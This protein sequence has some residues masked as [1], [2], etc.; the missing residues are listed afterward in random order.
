MK[1]ALPY[2]LAIA[3]LL[4]AGS[5][6]AQ[7]LVS[8]TPRDTLT[9]PEASFRL[10]AFGLFPQYDVEIADVRYTMADIGGA[11]D[12]VSGAVARPLAPA[13]TA[14]PRLAY[15][16]GTT[17][18][19]F[20]VPS[21]ASESAFE[22]T[23]LLATQGYLTVGPDYLGMGEDEGFHPYVHAR[24]EA[25][26]GIRMLQAL[27]TD[28]TYAAAANEQLFLTGYSQGG[29]ASMAMH[30]L[31]VEE[32]SGEFDVT[33]AA[34][35]SGPYSISTVMKDTVILRD[36]AFTSPAFLPYT[37]LGYMTAYPELERG[38]D[39][40]FRAPYVALVERFRDE[41]EAGTYPL[42]ELNEDLLRTYAEVEGDSAFFPGRYLDIDFFQ[43]LRKDVDD[44]FNV[45]LRENDVF[46]FENPDPTELLY[47]RGDDQVTYLNATVAL[48]S[49]LARGATATTARNLGD[50]RDH[51]RCALPA[52]ANAARFFAT[53]Q[54]VTSATEI[55]GAGAWTYAQ[56]EGGLRVYL[57]A[58][59]GARYR[60][61]LVDA[62]GRVAAEVAHYTSGDFVA[63]AGLPAGLAV[64]RIT[65]DRGRAA[66]RKLILR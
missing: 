24:T 31:I 25:L 36:S 9:S 5:A 35:L 20:D 6:R 53:F 22:P 11:I 63:T 4:S 18:T 38:L 17:A 29:H 46:D 49:L 15:M 34:H 61:E 52:F 13:G 26:A 60:L 23:F 10:Q 64:A 1:H 58:E 41:Y 12:T 8:V 40:I 47:C 21:R 45:R 16:H 37:V 56:A 66:T 50:D 42:T 44:P 48:D 43:T 28:D 27:A 59:A 54:E 65:D 62:L 30:E 55:P 32:F 51:F 3:T 7:D 2:V 14:F 39:D 33:A 57:D 19:K